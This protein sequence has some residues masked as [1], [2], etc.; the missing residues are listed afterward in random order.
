MY[1]EFNVIP[2]QPDYSSLISLK[3]IISVCSAI[4]CV[5]NEDKSNQTVKQCDSNYKACSVL[6]TG[7]TAKEA[8]ITSRACWNHA[9]TR[10][11]D[12]CPFG[13]CIPRKLEVDTIP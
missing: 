9:E 3:V 5:L 12:N 1:L 10:H 4:R 7:P 11:L 6:W 8:V 13:P 2:L